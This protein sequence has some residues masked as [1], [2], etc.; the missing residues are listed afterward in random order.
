MINISHSDRKTWKK[1]QRRHFFSSSLYQARVTE[2]FSIHLIFGSAIHLALEYFYGNDRDLIGALTIMQ[3]YLKEE[4]DDDELYEEYY[5]LGMVMLSGYYRFSQEED[6]FEII[7]TE[8]PFKVP[9]PIP[10]DEVMLRDRMEILMMQNI[11]GL[12]INQL[13]ILVLLI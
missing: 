4:I 1:C 5:E 8:F 3:D 7:A 6:N 13:I 9:I 11:Y 12:I 10:K 2:T